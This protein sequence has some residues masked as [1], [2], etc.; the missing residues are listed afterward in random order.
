MRIWNATSK[1][2]QMR[3]LMSFVSLSTWF[4]ECAVCSVHGMT[5]NK[6]KPNESKRNDIDQM[7]WMRNEIK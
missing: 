4:T 7:T 3:L 2:I 6:T 1:S 5:R